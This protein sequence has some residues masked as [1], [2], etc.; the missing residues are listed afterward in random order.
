LNGAGAVIGAEP[1]K[2]LAETDLLKVYV[3]LGWG[4]VR[5]D[6]KKLKLELTP[7]VDGAAAAAAVMIQEGHCCKHV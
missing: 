2:G 5:D 1:L 4:D 3:E 7:G 6:F